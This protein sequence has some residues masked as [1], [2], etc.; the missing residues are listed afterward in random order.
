MNGSPKQRSNRWSRW[1]AAAFVFTMLATA[2]SLACTD[3]SSSAETEAIPDA[4]V[5]VHK[6]L[7]A[8]PSEAGLA[9]VEA[10]ADVHARADGAAARGAP[11]AELSVI[12]REGVALAVPEPLRGG[13][14]RLESDIGV[15]RLELLAR[16]SE[17]RLG[18]DEGAAEV[19]SLLGPVLLPK[20][21]LPLDRATARALVA[22]GDAAFEEGDD[23]LAV[24]SYARAIRVMTMLQRE[25]VE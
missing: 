14:D 16:F 13:D 3:L 6:V 22:L 8:T 17:T 2:G 21:S 7:P 18:E 23:A 5:R 11:A 25:L 4:T 10:I 12:L 1:R 15:V 24:G 20:R 9:Y 19:V